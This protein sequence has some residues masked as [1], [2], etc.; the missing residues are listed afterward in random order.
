MAKG[1]HSVGILILLIAMV[2]YL[3]GNTLW[4]G[5]SVLGFLV[6]IVGWVVWVSQGRGNNGSN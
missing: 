3:L 2:L 5:I 1:I 6:E 4:L